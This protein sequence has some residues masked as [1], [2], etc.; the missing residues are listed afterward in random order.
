MSEDSF[1]ATT[2][3]EYLAEC[4]EH[5]S[6]YEQLL[7]DQLSAPA[8]T[9]KGKV[10]YLAVAF[11]E[12]LARR[13][14]ELTRGAIQLYK[15]KLLVPGAVVT[16]S[17]SETVAVMYY[18]AKK[19]R[20]AQTLKDFHEVG[21]VLHR[22]VW[23]GK[24]DGVPTAPIQVL[25][26]LKHIDKAYPGIRA[27][28]DFLCELSHPNGYG[29]GLSY[30]AYTTAGREAFFAQPAELGASSSNLPMGPFGLGNHAILLEVAVKVYEE[31]REVTPDFIKKLHEI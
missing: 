23:G 2:D 26:A 22:G 28:Y 17:T 3:V 27:D 16:R 21:I 15:Y 14:C 12:L 13:I 1:D 7:E 5:M 29:V 6:C 19:M 9:E 20:M 31:C 4:E 24:S 30:A 10:E 11:R 18:G 8:D 25:T